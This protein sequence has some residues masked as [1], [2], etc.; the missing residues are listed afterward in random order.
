[1]TTLRELFA[2]AVNVDDHPIEYY[3]TLSIKWRADDND[4]AGG[5]LEINYQ[6]KDGGALSYAGV[7]HPGKGFCEGNP[8]AYCGKAYYD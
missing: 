7:F 3:E 5:Y 2:I 4:P 1:M 8:C 6:V